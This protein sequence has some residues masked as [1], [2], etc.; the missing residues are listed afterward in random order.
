MART[1]AIVLTLVAICSL[2]GPG[3]AEEPYD[4]YMITS[5]TGSGAFLGRDQ[6][7]SAQAAERYVNAHG[8]IRGRTLRIVIVDDQSNPGTAVAVATPIIAKGVPIVLGPTLGATC[9]AVA[10]LTMT[11]G[12]TEY[13]MTSVGQMASGSYGFLWGVQ[14]GAYQANAFRYLKAKGV[15]KIGLLVTTDATGLEA[16]KTVREALQDA[17]LRDLQI[18]AV[19]HFAPADLTVSAQLA[20]IKAAGAEAIDAFV[21]GTPLGTVLRGV[22]DVGFSGYVFAPASNASAEQLR[23]YAAFL[24]DKLVIA[25]FGYYLTAGVSPRVTAAKGVFREAMRQIGVTEPSTGNVVAWD[26]LMIV[27]AA[28]RKYGPS[29]TARDA[30]DFIL[31]LRGWPGINGLYDFGHG[32]QRGI[33]PRSTGLVRFDKTTG[34]FVVLSK[35]GGEPL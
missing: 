5:Q 19:E 1:T 13:C 18:V 7:A 22:S 27:I 14:T 16:E 23:Q 2:A 20:R 29:M 30:R 6:V 31:S 26:P 17:E 33:D 3:R 24:P 25:A 12:P 28:L 15:R 21:T 8:G 4:L 34:T 32:D 10:P 11:N 9:G 35:P